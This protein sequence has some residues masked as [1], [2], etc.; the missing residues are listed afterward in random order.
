MRLVL[1]LDGDVNLESVFL[2]GLLLDMQT[3]PI[4]SMLLL[5]WSPLGSHIG[6]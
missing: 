2:Q 5:V 6:K 3:S 1:D 4:L